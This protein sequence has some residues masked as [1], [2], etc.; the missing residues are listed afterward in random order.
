M[1]DAVRRLLASTLNC[2][3]AGLASLRCHTLQSADLLRD[4]EVTEVGVANMQTNWLT[5]PL[6]DDLLAEQTRCPRT[7]REDGAQLADR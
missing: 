6:P 3:A 4:E 7:V 2:A 5:I 1:A